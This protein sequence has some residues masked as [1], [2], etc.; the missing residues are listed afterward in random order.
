MLTRAAARHARH[1]QRLSSQE[2]SSRGTTLCA[3]EVAR[4]RPRK[5]ARPGNGQSQPER[6]GALASRALNVL[7]KSIPQPLRR[8]RRLAPPLPIKGLGQ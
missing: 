5:G 8:S 7:L 4:K 2:N 1:C 3:V 6:H